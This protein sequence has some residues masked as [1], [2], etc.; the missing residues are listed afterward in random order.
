MDA[1]LRDR[2][3]WYDVR[4][5]VTRFG[6]GRD[7]RELGLPAR[8]PT[9]FPGTVRCLVVVAIVVA[10]LSAAP[11]AAQHERTEGHLTGQLLVASAN[12][13]D[14]RFMQTVI[15]V[16]SHGADG[17]MGL[18][19]NRALGVAPI[20]VLLDEF[21]I[22]DSE[23]PGE[24]RVHYGGPVERGRGFVLHSSDFLGEGTVAV[25]GDVALSADVEI[26]RAIAEDRGPGRS[27]FALG[28]AGWAPGQLESEI[29]RDD[30]FSVPLD[31]N[32]VF[33]DALDT[34]WDRAFDRRGI[35]L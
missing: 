7:M 14:P 20:S 8:R 19:L 25:N 5:S 32:L 12:M 33:D 30:W 15:Y 2:F 13:G 24:V 34:K 28:Y 9:V 3:C 16:V 35:D 4:P 18:V 17:A 29:A 26:L 10:A 31:L 23:A 21:G 6:D 27:L 22:A 11:L 1:P